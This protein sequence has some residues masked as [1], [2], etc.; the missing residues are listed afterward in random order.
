MIAPL[1]ALTQ[2]MIPG[3]R[4]RVPAIECVKVWKQY[5]FHQHRP[6]KIKDALFEMIGGRARD[7]RDAVW[8]L[9]SF[10]LTVYPGETVGVVGH[11]GS[12]KSTLL[13]LLSKII[14]PTTGHVHI[15]G[16]L[17]ALIELG[18]GFCEDLTA[19]ENVY[20]A[21]S[22]LGFNKRD[23]DQMYPGIVDFSELSD[24]ME[25]PVKY[26]SSGMQARLGFSIAI[27]VNPDILLIDEILAVGDADFQPK[28]KAAIKNFQ[29]QGK[30]ILFV[31]H[32]LSAVHDLCT[33]VIWMKEGKIAADGPPAQTLDTYLEHYWPGCT[34]HKSF[35]KLAS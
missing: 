9:Q 34:A 31:S 16:R 2:Q 10:S 35:A 7:A 4:C 17:S 1:E 27:N 18:A 28:C 8:A 21:A 32:D 20:L 25:T 23:V 30:A 6:R 33:R 14:Q 5:Y 19:K 12:G 29:H 3:L 22:F 24:H 15:S 13:K 26:F 11:N